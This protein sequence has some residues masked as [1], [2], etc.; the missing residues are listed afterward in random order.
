MRDN[1]G[2]H[3]RHDRRLQRHGRVSLP[4]RRSGVRRRRPRATAPAPRWSRGASA[5]AAAPASPSM[6][7]SCNGYRC[8]VNAGTA[9]CGTTCSADADCAPNAFCSASACHPKGSVNLAGN[10]DLETGTTT[11]WSPAFGSG[12]IA[13][14]AVASG[15]VS[16]GRRLFGRRHEPHRQLTRA[17]ATPCRPDRENTSSAP[18]A[19]SETWPAINGHLQV[20]LACADEHELRRR[21]GS[22]FRWPRTSG[23]RSAPPSTPPCTAVD[24]LPTGAAP[25]VVRSAFA[26]PQSRR[27]TL[28]TPYP[29]LYL[30]DLV[31]QVTDGHNL[32]G[33]PNFEA[34]LADGWSLSAGSSTVTI[35]STA[36]HGGTKSMHQSGRS[37]PAAGPRWLLPTGAARYAHFVLGAAHACPQG[38]DTQATY[39]LMLQPTYNCINMPAPTTLPPPIGTVTAVPKDTWVE[40]KGTATFPPADAP[41]GCKLS[42][43]AVYVRHEGTAC[44][45]ANVPSC[46]STT[47][48]S[49]SRPER[50]TGAAAPRRALRVSATCARLAPL[51]HLQASLRT[52]RPPP[53]VAQ[54]TDQLLEKQRRSVRILRKQL[55]SFNR[56]HGSA[57]LTHGGEIAWRGKTKCEI[58]V[59]V[60]F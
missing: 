22:T 5:T 27:W 48:R 50:V 38:G 43:A 1:V 57:D 35:D 21:R 37:I 9:A 20:R 13:L 47:S 49:R 58:V 7:Q 15:G 39:D 42:L 44:S 23:R 34:G 24:C 45:G 31:V 56:G 28:P 53:R 4:P 12:T 18:G 19:C 30:D 6:S 14:S 52:R 17:P 60:L 40:L 26:L 36:A 2:Q 54:Q 51:K 8:A 29:N 59:C 46:S 25:G 16:N 32:V 55:I 10:G 3:V 33:N 11:G 41:A